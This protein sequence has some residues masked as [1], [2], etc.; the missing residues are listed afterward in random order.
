METQRAI[1]ILLPDDADL[2]A[3]LKAFCAV[4]NAVSET[5]YNGGKPLRA[6][7]LQRVVYEQV[8]GTLSSQ[9]TIT[10][11]RVVAG[12]YASAKRIYARRVRAEARRKTRYEAKGW[13]YKPRVIKPVGVC[14]RLFR[15]GNSGPPRQRMCSF[16][17]ALGPTWVQQGVRRGESPR[18]SGR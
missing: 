9:M 2:H 14:A 8:K 13:T 15:G 16:A 3:T 12:G 11:L 7:E 1:T 17:P 10:A 5:A 6:V 4:Q 18:P